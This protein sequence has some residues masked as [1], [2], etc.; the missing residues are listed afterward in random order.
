[1]KSLIAAAVVLGSLALAPAA[2]AVEHEHH[3]GID[4][5]G[6]VLVIGDKSTS[7]FGGTAM[8]HYTYGLSDA[9]DLMFEGSYSLVALGQTADSPQTPRTYPAWIA[10]ANVGIG[11]V[12]DVLTW[13]PYVGILVG[14]Y[15][16]SGGTI[17][18]MKI[19]PGAE[20]AA[21]LDYRLGS[22]AAIGVALRQHLLSET[23]TY[24]S[25][26]QVLAR[27]ELIWGW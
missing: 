15:G 5:G 1:M 3:L 18:S 19:L 21:G 22:S 6:N 26:T 2:R 16:L 20:I 14:G 24:P 12:F 4:V 23:D 10:N 25:F 13:V 17:P 8:V 27:F 11:Y 9:F 7:D